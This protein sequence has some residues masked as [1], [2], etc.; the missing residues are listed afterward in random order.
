MSLLADFGLAVIG[1]A[2]MA[3][4]RSGRDQFVGGALVIVAAMLTAL[5]ASMAGI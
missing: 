3:F 1:V 5:H 2:I 4:A